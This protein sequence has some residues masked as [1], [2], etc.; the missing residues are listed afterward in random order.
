MFVASSQKV[1]VTCQFT[2]F[3]G[4]EIRW[5]LKYIFLLISFILFLGSLQL[6]TLQPPLMET[7]CYKG[8]HYQ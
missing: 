3:L 6:V 2:A 8:G 1:H 4:N 7:V 5:A